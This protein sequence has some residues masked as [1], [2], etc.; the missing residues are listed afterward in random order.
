[1]LKRAILPLRTFLFN[2]RRFPEEVLGT[3]N[4]AVCNCDDASTQHT[5]LDLLHRIII[6]NTPHAIMRSEAIVATE[7]VR[8]FHHLFRTS[9]SDTSVFTT[10]EVDA[11]RETVTE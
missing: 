5:R 4:I 8:S 7:T 10:G 1:M 2:Y 6:A 11:P 9:R 3:A